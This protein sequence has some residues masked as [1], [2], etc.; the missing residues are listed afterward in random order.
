MRR[1]STCIPLSFA[2]LAVLLFTSCATADFFPDAGSLGPKDS[3]PAGSPQ[4][5]KSSVKEV[6]FRT[7]NDRTDIKIVADGP[8][9]FFAYRLENPNRIAIEMENMGHKLAQP[10]LIINDKLVDKV[11]VVNFDRVKKIRVEIWIKVPYTYNVEKAFASLTITVKEDPTSDAAALTRAKKVI[12]DL[13]VEILRLK[14]KLETVERREEEMFA[15]PAPQAEFEPVK[16]ALEDPSAPQ[17]V[18]TAQDG[19]AVAPQEQA[20][21]ADNDFLEVSKTVLGWREAWEAKNFDRYVNYYAP[22]FPGSASAR[23]AWL[24]DKRK[25]FEKAGG[26]KVEIMNLE[27]KVENGKTTIGFT[28]RYTSGRHSDVGAKTLILVK[29]GVEW[30]IDSE[31]W[32]SGK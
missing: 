17:A 11:T 3:S 4:T 7:L 22:A 16:G 12:D 15:Q 26:I 21:K 28:Q 2:S 18:L 13:N 9:R 20:T 30:K 6:L 32:R 27:T 23:L 1:I 31:E 8:V 19:K 24:A 29:Y 10:Q 14:E 5:K 25:R